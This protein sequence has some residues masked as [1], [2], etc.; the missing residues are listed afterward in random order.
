M[1]KTICKFWY[2]WL[3]SEKKAKKEPIQEKKLK[4]KSS[5]YPQNYPRDHKDLFVYL[6]NEFKEFGTMKGYSIPKF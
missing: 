3:F 5:I 2:K 1:N 6:G 4:V